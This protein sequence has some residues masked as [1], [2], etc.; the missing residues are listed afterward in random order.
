MMGMTGT[1]GLITARMTARIL[2]STVVIAFSGCATTATIGRTDG[3]DSEAEIIRSNEEALF[4]RGSNGQIYRLERSTVSDI[5][6]PGNVVM[7]VGASLIGMLGLLLAAMNPTERRGAVGPLTIGY[8]LPGLFLLG[9]GGNRYNQ[10]VTAARAFVNAPGPELPAPPARL[11]DR[12]G[13][14]SSDPRETPTG[15]VVKR[16]TVEPAGV[17]SSPL[18]PPTPPAEPG[19]A[20]DGVPLV[21]PSPLPPQ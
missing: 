15:P 10:S 21:A 7:V 17:D 5:D 8:G 13:P 20:T 2:A 12:S 16:V 18:L 4:V 14:F 19:H 9:L 11:D 3:P 6:H 1:A